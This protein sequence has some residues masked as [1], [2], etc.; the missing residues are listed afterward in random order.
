MKNLFLFSFITFSIY[1]SQLNIA[2]AMSVTPAVKKEISNIDF[3][4]DLYIHYSSESK[5]EVSAKWV[6]KCEIANRSF[7]TGSDIKYKVKLL[8]PIYKCNVGAMPFQG[9][10]LFLLSIKNKL[11]LRHELT[12]KSLT[13][14]VNS[15]IENK[16]YVGELAQ[17]ETA[18]P[19]K[20]FSD[21]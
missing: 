3:S 6:R 16:I 4:G 18:D 12:W 9:N 5:S 8:S 2:N 15:I 19:K 1:L 11:Y 10:H 13:Y 14:E 20:S 17:Y 21:I 7:K